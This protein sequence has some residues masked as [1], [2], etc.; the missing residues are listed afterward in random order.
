MTSGDWP[1]VQI[2]TTV[3]HADA[4][5][6]W[7]FA[8]GALSV[9]FRDE[10]DQPI[11]EPA[12]GEVRLWDALKLVGLFA[13]N[14]SD[15]DVHA[16]LLLAAAAADT[17]APV[18]TLSRLKDTAWERT[19]MESFKPM[20]FGEQLWV[21]P[22]YQD[23]PEPEAVNVRLDPGLAFGSGTHPTTAQVLRYLGAGTT[24]LTGLDVIDFGCGSGILAVAAALLGAKS[25][26]AVDIDPQAIEAT[27]QNAKANNVARTIVTGLPSILD[28]EQ[29]CDLM[30]A[31][32]LCEPLLQLA[33]RMAEMVVTGGT[34]VMSGVLL[35]QIDS[36]R[37]GY[38]EWFH[39]DQIGNQDEWALL[40]ASKR[41]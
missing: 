7:L 14:S 29:S 39:F 30:L 10:K 23:A 17:Q 16:A 41:A 1:E 8:A 18:Y 3:E 34:L 31:N 28:V 5:E 13:Q 22:T 4:V 33:P 35:E 9:T 21:C 26:R 27:Q 11:L 2:S 12:P 38:N 40:V 20:Q 37:L 19:W 15:D 36:I 6:A 25:V 32:I 24:S